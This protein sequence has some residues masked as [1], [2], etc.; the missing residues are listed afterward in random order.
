[1]SS[2]DALTFDEGSER[3][4]YFHAYLVAN[5]RPVDAAVA[6]HLGQKVSGQE[7]A[8]KNIEQEQFAKLF[9]HGKT[10]DG[11]QKVWL[12]SDNHNPSDAP[13]IKAIIQDYKK[14]YDHMKTLA[15]K[16]Q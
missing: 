3:N 15:K 9:A 2:N 11:L 7:E 16:E 5:L 13:S 14:Y 4:Q 8:M 1:M 12:S 10:P 6:L